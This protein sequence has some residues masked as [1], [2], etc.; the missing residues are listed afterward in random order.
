MY[1]RYSESTF[2]T[3][4]SGVRMGE[5]WLTGLIWA[6]SSFLLYSMMAWMALPARAAWMEVGNTYKKSWRTKKENEK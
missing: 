2:D 3:I 5:S 4:I 6:L 1:S